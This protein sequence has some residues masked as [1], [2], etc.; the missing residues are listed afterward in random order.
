M[1]KRYDAEYIQW[2]IKTLTRERA[3]MIFYEFWAMVDRELEKGS[4]K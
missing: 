4:V 2:M 1:K 3:G